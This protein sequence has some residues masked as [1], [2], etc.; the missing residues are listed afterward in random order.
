VLRQSGGA[1]ELLDVG[2]R[3]QNFPRCPGLKRWFLKGTKGDFFDSLQAAEQV[4]LPVTYNRG[5]WS[6][7][8]SLQDTGVGHLVI[9]TFER[10][11]GGGGGR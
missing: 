7:A 9:L 8:V 10:R 11:G 5:I 6:T 1:L 3:L 4:R 2:E